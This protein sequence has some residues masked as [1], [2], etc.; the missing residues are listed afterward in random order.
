MTLVAGLLHDELDVM[1]DDQKRMQKKRRSEDQNEKQLVRQPVHRPGRFIQEGR[2]A[3][4]I[5][6]PR[7][8]DFAQHVGPEIDN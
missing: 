1:L 8:R 6:E 5:A 3:E 7:A 2:E 4:A